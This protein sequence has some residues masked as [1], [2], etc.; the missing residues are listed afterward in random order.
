MTHLVSFGAF[1]PP[2]S[3]HQFSKYLRAQPLQSALWE[4]VPKWY[5]TLPPDHIDQVEINDSTMVSNTKI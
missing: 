2:D 3:M 4:L 5:K 1:Y